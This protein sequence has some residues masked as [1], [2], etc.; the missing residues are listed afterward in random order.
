MKAKAI[1]FTGVNEV[2]VADADVPEPGP[3]EVLVQARYTCISPGTELR[4]LAGQQPGAAP[5]PFVPGYSMVGT[6]I[7]RGPDTSLQEGATVFCSGTA[8]VNYGRTWGGHISHAVRRE[9]A[10]YPLPEGVDPLEAALAKLAAIA[11]HGVRLSRPL[12]HER[13]AVVGLGPIGQLSARLHHAA[14]ARV[15]ASDLSVE[16]VAIARSAGIEAIAVESSLA[17][18]YASVFPDGADIV[19]DATGAPGVL[20]QAMAVARDKPWDDTPVPGARVLIQGSYPDEFP[21]SYR[22]AF[23]KELTLLVPRDQQPTDLRAA[24]DLMQRGQLRVRD[25]ISDVRAPEAAPETYAELR[26]EKG[27]TLTVVFQWS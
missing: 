27:R 18:A 8:R 13:V 25:L 2:A 3:G 9:D 24:I 14:G 7:A 19:V 21:I 12:P 10:V 17:D 20:T 16:R 5:W 15:V 4:C 6:V 23:S 22:A 26:R 11:Y 1:L